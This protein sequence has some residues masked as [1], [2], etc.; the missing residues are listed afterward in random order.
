MTCPQSQSANGNFIS[1]LSTSVHLKLW[2]AYDSPGES[3]LKRDADTVDR[4]WDPCDSALLTSLQM[5]LKLLVHGHTWRGK[6]L[7]HDEHPWAPENLSSLEMHFVLISVLSS[8]G[9]CGYPSLGSISW[10][11]ENPF[12]LIQKRGR[13]SLRIQSSWNT[14]IANTI[15]QRS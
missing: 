13:D 5:T 14:R 15:H 8:L 7:D 9:L 3:G 2:S 6:A 10:S 4:G 11:Y 1:P 12:K